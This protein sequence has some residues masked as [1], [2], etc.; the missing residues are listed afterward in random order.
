MLIYISTFITGSAFY[1]SVIE[2]SRIIYLDIIMKIYVYKPL[3]TLN[4]YCTMLMIISPLAI[5]FVRARN[6]ANAD[7]S[8]LSVFDTN[9]TE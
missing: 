1:F 9:G 6:D 8:K 3:R 5:C 4:R 2:T 7:A